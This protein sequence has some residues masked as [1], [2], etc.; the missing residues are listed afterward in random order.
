MHFSPFFDGGIRPA[1]L[2]VA[3]KTRFSWWERSIFR[4][5]HFSVRYQNS[6]WM[7]ELEKKWLVPYPA[8]QD[9]LATT[10]TQGSQPGLF[11]CSSGRT[12]GAHD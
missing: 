6:G 2:S 10:L 8:R 1:L 12:E 5:G 4:S 7:P 9:R 11:S 3:A